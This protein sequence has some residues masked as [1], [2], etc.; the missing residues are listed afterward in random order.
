[1]KVSV[2]AGKDEGARKIEVEVEG[3]PGDEITKENGKAVLKSLIEFA[4]GEHVIAAKAR[5]SLVVDIQAFVRSRM[6]GEKPKTDKEIHAEVAE[7]RPSITTRKTKVE[8]V[9]SD[10]EELRNSNPEMFAEL[11]KGIK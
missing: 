4:G 6:T 1:M 9:K 7:W 8:R 3:L 11:L 2:S 10:L 5:A